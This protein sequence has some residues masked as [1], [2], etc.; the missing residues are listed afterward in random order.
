MSRLIS[1]FFIAFLW[2]PTA[3]SAQQVQLLT[4]SYPP[5][6]HVV[7]GKL[8]GVGADVM[9]AIIKELGEQPEIRVLPWKRAYN[10]VQEE[11]NVGLF[12]TTR[13]APREKL[14]QWVGPL[15]KV[16]DY[17]FAH[18][19]FS[20]SIRSLED[21]RAMRSILVQNG[22]GSHTLLKEL[23]FQ[24]LIPYT[25]TDRRLNMII[26]GR[27]ELLYLSDMTAYYQMRQDDISPRDVKPTYKIRESELYLVFSLKT[28][29]NL[30]ARWQQAYEAIKDR[31]DWQRI[32]GR[33]LPPGG[34]WQI[35]GG[36][37]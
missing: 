15:F 14:F 17:L 16:Q 33:Y 7:D 2:L 10:R 24:N 3:V 6:N 19:D 12:S 27:A 28:D 1:C 32:V 23:G 26:L 21:A 9:K 35:Q 20:F 5:F 31:G 4:E 30:V 29:P 11:A 18:R 34:I 37:S 22:G 8:T 13:V 25:Q 36:E